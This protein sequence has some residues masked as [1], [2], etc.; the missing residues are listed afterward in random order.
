M[1]TLDK[2][3]GH[4][5]F[6]SFFEGLKIKSFIAEKTPQ[7]GNPHSSF[8]GA[9]LQ[10]FMDDQI[11]HSRRTSYSRVQVCLSLCDVSE[12]REEEETKTFHIQKLK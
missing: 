6:K 5:S 3:G 10:C 2:T 9:E 11:F 4:I 7:R 12:P 8:A 1:E